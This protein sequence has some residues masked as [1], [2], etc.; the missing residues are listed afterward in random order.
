MFRILVTDVL[1]N[2]LDFLAGELNFEV[3]YCSKDDL[4][5]FEK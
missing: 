5:V 1:H 2:V 4:N 3:K